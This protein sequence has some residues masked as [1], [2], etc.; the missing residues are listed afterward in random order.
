MCIV[1]DRKGNKLLEMISGNEMEL[2]A[3]EQYR[4]LVSALVV[5]RSPAG[6]MLLMNKYRNEYELAGG[7]IEP[8]ETPRE[9]AIRECMEESGYQ[10]SDARFIGIMKFDLVPDYF[11][12]EYRIE[13]TALY[14]ADVDEIIA[15]TENDEMSGL[16]WYRIG[17]KIHDA[18]AI[19]VKLLEYYEL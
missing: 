8:G 10:L 15:F 13:Y 18:S 17:D 6:F 2:I 19:D 3:N 11:S 12:K 9:C 7:I 1:T 16:C 4:P 5:V 14:G